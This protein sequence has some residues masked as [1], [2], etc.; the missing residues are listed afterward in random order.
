MTACGAQHTTCLTNEGE[1]YSWGVGKF[2]ALGNGSLEDQLIPKKIEG[3]SKKIVKVE[4][5]SDFTLALTEDN[6]LYSWG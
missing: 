3:I 5:G 2:G 6:H 4:C 1:I